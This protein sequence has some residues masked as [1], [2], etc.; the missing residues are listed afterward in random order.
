VLAA[1]RLR[2][3]PPRRERGSSADALA[4]LSQVTGMLSLALVLNDLELA[5]E[6]LDWLVA[7]ES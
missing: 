5:G 6:S 1:T 7:S 2:R 4:T 3:A